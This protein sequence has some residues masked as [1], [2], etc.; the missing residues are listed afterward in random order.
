M[1]RDVSPVNE[2]LYG[3]LFELSVGE[4]HAD[5]VVSNRIQHPQV[6]THADEKLWRKI[7]QE[8]LPEGSGLER[9]REKDDVKLCQL[10]WKRD[11]TWRSPSREFSASRVRTRDRPPPRTVSPPRPAGSVL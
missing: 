6:P 10:F 3:H 11:V 9:E 1:K 5:S 4:R 7:A 8:T 2:H